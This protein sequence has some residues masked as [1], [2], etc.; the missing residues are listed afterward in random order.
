[1]KTIYDAITFSAFEVGIDL[2]KSTEMD[3][4]SLLG[5]Y[6]NTISGFNLIEQITF[7]LRKMGYTYEEIGKYRGINERSVYQSMSRLSK[8]YDI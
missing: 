1:M 3:P 4:D 5:K 7:L 6:I 8:R 2:I